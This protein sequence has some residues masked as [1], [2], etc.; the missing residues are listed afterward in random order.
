M[1]SITSSGVGS[2]IDIKGLISQLITAERTP[3]E[4]RLNRR[5]A[6]LQTRIS[7][8]GGFKG[9]LSTF[10][11]ALSSIK[12]AATF[13]ASAK[14]TVANDKLFTA[15]ASSTAPAGSYSVKVDN[16]AQSQKLVT[17]PA[18]NIQQDPNQYVVGTGTL[19]FQF[20]TYDSGGNTFTANANKA[21][22]TVTIDASNNSLNGVAKAINDAKIGVTATVINDGANGWRLTMS[23]TDTGAANSLKVTTTD[24]D[25]NDTNAAG[26]SIL[27]YDPTKTAGTGKNMQQPVGQDAKDASVIID[28]L[29]ITS[30][31]N[32]LSTAIQGVTL[33]LREANTTATTL[34]VAKDNSAI[35][36][37]VQS[38][39]KAFN[40]LAGTVKSLT[41]YNAETKESGVLQGD[42]SVRAIFGQI[43]SELNKVVTGAS[44]QFDSLADLG[45]S[46]NRD[47][48]LALDSAK[49]QKA[50]E[51][52]PQGVA[53]LFAKAGRTSDRLVNYVGSTSESR[54]GNYAVAVSQLA[55]QGS[56]TGIAATAFNITATNNTFALK[57]NGTQSGTLTLTQGSYT[58]SQLVAELQSRINGDSALQ[59][60]SASVGV[61]FSTTTSKFSFT[62]NSY[63]GSSAVEFTAVGASTETTLGFSA[64]VGVKTAGLDAQGTIGGTA[65]TGSGRKL[66]G[67]GGGAAGLAVEVVGGAT[68]DRGEVSL[69][70]G[71][72]ARLDTML[73]S[74]LGKNSP[75]TARADS[76]NQQVG[77]ISD[78]RSTLDNR[79]TALEKRYNAQFR[80]MDTLVSQLT[81]T[82]NYLA[83][84]FNNNSSNN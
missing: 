3:V 74:L 67:T 1:A 16:L 20:G 31:S 2:G 46:T 79:M 59:T 9:A 83:Q 27:A 14:A 29:T 47:G 58:S 70:D 24:G 11:S 23:S 17:D 15:S 69:S 76:L 71:L 12:D 10:Q 18:L 7:A 40:E 13:Q 41:S 5:E 19:T 53:G 57:V 84:Q 48:T 8:L 32:T 63:G 55:T 50:I 36:G 62:S 35:S 60:A 34:T 52:D 72:A 39:V 43:R 81:A 6:D 51:T 54:T 37:G 64:G 33:N 68:G 21:V 80:A 25:G 61:S 77:R 78:Q 28:G 66:T 26:L 49:L 45:I 42:F 38:F 22:K 73:T 56:Y 65:A 75:L 82:G 4:S 30:A 44:T